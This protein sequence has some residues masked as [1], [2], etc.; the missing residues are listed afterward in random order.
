MHI[1][2][3][4]KG[5][6]SPSISCSLLTLLTKRGVILK[7]WQLLLYFTNSFG[8]KE[9]NDSGPQSKIPPELPPPAEV[10]LQPWEFGSKLPNSSSIKRGR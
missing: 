1:L 7:V 9:T 8:G 6:F 2:S 4:T 3:H 10:S 5:A